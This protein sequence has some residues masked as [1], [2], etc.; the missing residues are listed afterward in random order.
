MAPNSL[1]LNHGH[2]LGSTAGTVYHGRNCDIIDEMKEAIMK[3]WHTL[4]EFFS[5]H[6]IGRWRHHQCVVDENGRQCASFA[7][8]PR[9]YNH[10]DITDVLN[11]FIVLTTF[12]ANY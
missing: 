8:C 10:C 6:S 9:M 7:N 3:E 5:D 2:H 1:D 12:V 4:A 11:V